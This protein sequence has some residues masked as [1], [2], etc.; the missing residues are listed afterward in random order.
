MRRLR[1]EAMKIPFIKMPKPDMDVFRSVF[2]D[3]VDAGHYSNFGP[4]EKRLTGMMERK[5]GGSVVMAANATMALEGIHHILSDMCGMAYLPGF[6]FPA[7]NLGCRVRHVFGETQTT[8]GMIGFAAYEPRGGATDYAVT[9]VP[10]GTAKPKEYSRPDVTFWIVDNAAGASPDMEKVAEWLDAG[11][12]AV[13][14]SL[15]ATKIMSGCEG[16]FAAF[17]NRM[18]Y[19]LYRKYVVFGFYLDEEGKK[20]SE[21]YGSNHKMSELSA[22]FAVMFYEEMLGPEYEGRKALMKEY[23]GFCTGRGLQFIPSPQAFWVRCR[24]DAEEVARKLAEKEIQAVPYYR[25]LW[26]AD[27]VDAGASMLSRSGLCLPTWNMGEE[28]R[29]YVVENLEAMVLG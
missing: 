19:E 18:L 28:E 14:C 12:D 24:T 4:N 9:A 1:D 10:F 13:V 8:G 26:R 6:T 3:S 23:S 21:K 17:R 11:A 15:H 29:R 2:Q 25:P 20:R 27:E 22:A 5:V 7:T 16:G